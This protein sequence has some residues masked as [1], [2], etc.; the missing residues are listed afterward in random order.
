LHSIAFDEAVKVG[1]LEWPDLGFYSEGWAE[2]AALVV[3]SGKTGFPLYGF[4]EDAVAGHWVAHGGLT[5]SKLRT[6]HVEL[7]Q[8]CEF[9]AYVLRAS[10]FRHLDEVL[11][12]EVLLALVAAREG[13]TPEAVEAVL[14]MSLDEVDAEWRAWVSARYAAHPNADSE[15][16]AYRT[17]VGGACRAWSESGG[18]PS[19][20]LERCF[21]RLVGAPPCTPEL[22]C[23]TVNG[24][25]G[26]DEAL[27]S[28]QGGGPQG[29]GMNSRPRGSRKER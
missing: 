2:Y 17:R 12:H 18:S 27:P 21:T 16:E 9:Q 20:E 1:A 14:G 24:G 6:A 11:G 10:W 5:L 7:N 13:W 3:H 4:D 25:C 19:R 26:S 29:S 22:A 8:R 23:K 28:S 15:A